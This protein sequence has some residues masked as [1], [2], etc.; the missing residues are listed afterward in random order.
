MIRPRK[1]FGDAWRA[2]LAAALL[3]PGLGSQAQ[4]NLL[5]GLVAYWPLDGNFEDAVGI[6]DGEEQGSTPIEFIQGR[7]GFNQAIRMNGEDQY[8]LITGGE[9]DDLAFEGGS[10]SIAGWFRVDAFDTEWQALVAKGEGTSWRVHRNGST[11]GFAHA[12]GV[13]EGPAGTPVDDGEWHH[14]VAITDAE[15]LAFGTRLYIDG[16]NYSENLA[17]PALAANGLRMRIGD[18]PGAVGREWEGAIDDIAIW[19]RV[20]TEDEV[21]Y[22]WNNGA[23][24]SIKSL[25]GVQI[26]ILGVGAEAL[27]GGDLTDPEDDGSE[28]AGPD[29]PSWNW[30]GISASHEPGFGGGE[31]AFNIFDNA[32]GGGNDKW[33]CDDPTPGN[34]VWVA[35]EFPGPVSITH[36]TVTSGN[37]SPERDPTDWA[38]QGSNDGSNYTDIY[39]FTGNPAPWTERNQ[40]LKFTLPEPSP[41]YRFIRYIAYETPGDLHQINEIE[42]FGVRGA[43]NIAFISAIRNS[44]TEFGFR[45]NDQGTSVVDPATVQLTLDGQAVNLGT[46]AKTDGMINVTYTPAQVFLPS[47]T[48]TYSI[49]AQDNFGNVLLSEGSFTTRAYAYLTDTD[50]VTPNTAQRGFIFNVH[51]NQAFQN[52]DNIRAARPQPRRRLRHRARAGCRNSPGAGQPAHTV[53]DRIGHQHEPGLRRRG[54]QHPR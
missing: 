17:P 10:M 18:N 14:F 40:V 21:E 27:L 15:A 2:A 48:H 30:A 11:S 50:K 9:P 6:F 28:E 16:Q 43:A 1:W 34:P 12:G 32:V 20:L 37:D 33:C 26:D 46:L 47:S 5:N 45:V 41:T 42:Y 23:G 31:F 53:R 49:R 13:G 52:N 3:L 44:I 24:R 7:P 8:I 25:Q 51:Q 36:F 22:L 19:D 38:I 29:D 4:V 35:V 39:H 54:R